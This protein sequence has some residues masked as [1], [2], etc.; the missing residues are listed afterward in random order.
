MTI[1]I[2]D[3]STE[4]GIV[5]IGQEGKVLVF[6]NLPFGLNNSQHL[7]PTINEEMRTLGLAPKDLTAVAVCIGPGSYT[8]IRVGAMTAKSIAYANEIPLIGICT[9][10]GFTPSKDG[11]FAVLVDAKV[12]GAYVLTAEKKQEKILN[13]SDPAVVDLKSL[14]PQISSIPTVVCPNS[15]RLEQE[16]EGEWEWEQSWPNPEHLLALAEQKYA[17]KDYTLDGKLELMYL[18]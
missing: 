14:T 9:L 1:L 4:R 15:S 2:L 5:A 6:R 13:M 12:A 11:S 7:M 18:R 8:G 17:D 3:T 10:E 16:M